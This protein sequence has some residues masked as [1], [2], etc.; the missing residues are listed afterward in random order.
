MA[1]ETGFT[2]GPRQPPA[3]VN[4]DD[5]LGGTLKELKAILYT[6]LEVHG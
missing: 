4:A 6:S 5:G 1:G 3:R 2:D